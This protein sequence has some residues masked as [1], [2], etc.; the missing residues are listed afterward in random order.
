MNT[1]EA[2]LKRRTIRKFQ[3]TP[4]PKESLMK[5]V[6]AARLAPS[7]GNLQPLKYVVI[8]DETLLESVFETTRW[9]AYVTP[10]GT[11]KQGERP[12]AYIVVLVDTRIRK[13]AD[14]EAGAAIAHVLLTAEE[15]GIGSCWIASVDTEAL[16]GLLSP[17]EGLAIHSVVAL[18]YPAQT[19]QVFEMKDGDVKYFMDGQ[20]NFHVPKRKLDEIVQFLE[21][22]RK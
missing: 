6:N 17:E 5:M 9:A 21:N 22:G 13:E 1:Y 15:E 7:G 12:T 16:A 19:S 11:P 14:N 18:G 2:I 3:A 8:T 4:I 20:G 10:H